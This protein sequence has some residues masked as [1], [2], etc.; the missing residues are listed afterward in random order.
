MSKSALYVVNN[1]TQ[2]VVVNGLI[3]PGNIIRRFGPNVNLINSAIQLD[4]QGYYSLDTSVTLAPT[5]AG[6]VTVS[7]F[8][9]GVLIPG[10][11]ATETVAAAGD[12]VNLSINALIREKMCYYYNEPSNLTFVLTGVDASITNI[13]TTV[14]KL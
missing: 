7:V 11:T 3:N 12:F 13:A 5:A 6:E 1:T 2:D 9:D 14:I 8:R 10:S 4:G